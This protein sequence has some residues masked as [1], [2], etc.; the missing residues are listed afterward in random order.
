[1]FIAAKIAFMLISYTAVHTFD[2]YIFTVIASSLHGFIT[3]QH[4]DQLPVCFLAHLV[5]HCFGIAEIMVS[6]PVQA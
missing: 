4:D 2:F 1:M 6:N 3:N 5:D